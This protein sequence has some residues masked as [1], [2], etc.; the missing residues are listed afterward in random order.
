MSKVYVVTS[1]EY[2]DY[3]IDSIYSTREA[4]EKCCAAWGGYDDKPMIEEYE[5]KDGSNIKVEH[6]YKALEF[7]MKFYRTLYIDWDM[8][9]GTKPFEEKINRREK[10]TMRDGRVRELYSGVIPVNKAITTDEE[11][12][13][14]VH[15]HIAKWKAEQMGL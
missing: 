13:K 5:L 6:V 11:A 3:G 4:A 2:S 7:S 9:Y 15:D 14:I 8:R 1:G 10:T 12:E